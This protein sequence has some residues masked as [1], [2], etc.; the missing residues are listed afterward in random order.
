[1]NCAKCGKIIAS[2]NKRGLCKVCSFKNK[3]PEIDYKRHNQFLKQAK[4]ILRDSNITYEKFS[5]LS[6]Y[7]YDTVERYFSLKY[8]SN[9]FTE[10]VNSILKK[11]GH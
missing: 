8:F 9:E 7:G 5:E 1:M 3:Y 11:L 4:A 6:G 10:I 2:T